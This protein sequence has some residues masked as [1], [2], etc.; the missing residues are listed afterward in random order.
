MGAFVVAVTTAI[1]TAGL[2]S[3]LQASETGAD[4]QSGTGHLRLSSAATGQSSSVAIATGAFGGLMATIDM[5]LVNGGREF[6]GAGD[7]RPTAFSNSVP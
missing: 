5:G 6:T 7:R 3:R 4:G 1:G 2:S